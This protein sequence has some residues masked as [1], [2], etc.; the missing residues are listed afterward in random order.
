MN[1]QLAADESTFQ[2]LGHSE[3]CAASREG[4]EHKI[5]F[6]ARGLNHSFQDLFHHIVEQ[7]SMTSVELLS[8][9]H[10]ERVMPDD[11]VPHG[12]AEPIQGDLHFG[13][14]LIAD[15]NPQ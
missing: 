11:P 14:V 2:P 8:A 10:A 5:S 15:R 3:R 1:R 7:V 13:C 9:V 12:E 6:V 4:V